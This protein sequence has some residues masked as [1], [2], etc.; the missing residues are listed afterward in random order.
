[1]VSMGY[2]VELN[3]WVTSRWVAYTGVR[4]GLPKSLAAQFN[5]RHTFD[6]R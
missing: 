6:I 4:E 1:M 5:V 2:M 3:I